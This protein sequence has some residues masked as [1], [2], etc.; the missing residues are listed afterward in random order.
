MM[1]KHKH[2]NTLKRRHLPIPAT[3]VFIRMKCVCG[4]RGWRVTHITR[5]LHFRAQLSRTLS[6]ESSCRSMTVIVQ[7]HVLGEQAMDVDQ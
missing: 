1:Q 5:Q 7:G 4:Y 6:E 2:A 3:A